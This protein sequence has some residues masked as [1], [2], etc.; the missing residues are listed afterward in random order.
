M[1]EI[2]V[3]KDGNFSKNSGHSSWLGYL[4]NSPPLPTPSSCMRTTAA[5]S[6]PSFFVDLCTPT[7]IVHQKLTF[8]EIYSRGHP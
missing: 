6:L 7:D 8:Y 3:T 5:V 2:F 4:G 1:F